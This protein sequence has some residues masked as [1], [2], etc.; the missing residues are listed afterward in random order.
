[1]TYMSQ[2]RA[3]RWVNRIYQWEALP[4]NANVNYFVDWDHFR[5][6]FRN[7]FYPLHANA[8]ATN[9]LEG[10]T[11]FQGD[12][13]VDDYLDDFRDLIAESGYTS[14]KTIVVKFRR[15][16]NPEIGDTVATMAA[17]RPDDLDPE[18]WYEAVVRIDQNQAMNAAFRGSIEAPNANHTLPREPTISEAE[19]KM[20][21]DKPKPSAVAPKP[22]EG[23][24]V[25]NIIGMSAD[26]IQ[27]LLRQLSPA[28]NSP[29]PTSHPKKP[30]TPIIP[31]AP[32]TCTNRFQGLVVEEAVKDN[33]DSH[34]VAEATCERQP[35][36]PQWEKK[37]PRQPKIGAA[38]VG[39]NS[40]YL[41]VEI[42]S[43]DTQR[44]YGVRALVDSGAT[45]LFIDREYVKSNQIPT[46]KL[47]QAVPVYNVDGSDNQDGVISEVAELLLW[48]NGHS[49]RA[50]FCVTGLGKQ[51]L[52]LGHTWLKDHNPEVDWRTGKVE[53]LRCSPRCCNA[54]R[55]EI[56]E[57][58]KLAKK[59]T[60]NVNA[61]RSGPFPTA[62]VRGLPSHLPN[63]L[64]TSRYRSLSLPS[65][66]AL[67]ES[68][69]RS[70]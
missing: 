1:M 48:Y 11:Y 32:I 65:S 33:L 63:S 20:S 27:R 60:A 58:S 68:L 12:H 28:D 3:Q 4:A 2:G 42:E 55:T 5:S 18:G 53:M 62:T 16:L 56:R 49:E 13:S 45:G 7:E 57:E 38:E 54:C 25:T 67:P 66:T 37:L 24:D 6:V 47:S 61:C 70:S 36:K 30:K 17:N 9:M 64:P 8:V 51:N 69:P 40:L 35:R 19:P 46:T 23:P 10:Q 22:D 43:T 50:L 52:I 59:E 39:L 29:T 14:P 15:G 34:P 26:D 44:K 21:E 31:A 41:R